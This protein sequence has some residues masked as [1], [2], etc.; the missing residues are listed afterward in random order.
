MEAIKAVISTPSVTPAKPEFAF[1]MTEEAAQKNFCILNKY[2]RD[3]GRA[4]A[5]QHKS[6]LGYGSEFRPTANLIHVFGLHP[7][8]K[9]MEALLQTGSDW[10]LDNLDMVSKSKDVEEA[11]QFGN[12]KG[13]E[14]NSE[15]LTSLVNKDVKHGYGLVLPLKKALRIPGLLMAPMNIQKQNTIDEF[16]RIMERDRLTHNQSYKWGS[17]TSVNSRVDKGPLLPCMFG[18]CLKRLINWTVAAR[19]KYPDTRILASKI[20]YKS[21]YRRC[22]LNA[23]T[24]IQTSTQLPDLNLLI[25]ALR[26]TFGGAPGP[27]EW[28]AISEPICDLAMAILQHPDWDPERLHAPNPELV[29]PAEIM[30][31]SIPFGVGRELIVDVPVDPRGTTDV[32]IDDTMGLTIDVAGSNNAMRLERAILLA[33]HVAAR[34]RHESEPIPR[35]EMAALAKLIA[36]AKLEERKTILG[37]N[38]DFRR[39]TISLPENK[40]EAWSRAIQDI[41]EEETVSAKELEKNIGRLVHLSLVLPFVHHFLSRLRELHRRANNRRKIKVTEIYKVDLELMLFFLKKAHQGVDMNLIA[42]R[43]PTHVFRSDSCPRGLGGYSH[44]G[45]AWRFYIPPELQFRASNNLLEHMAS[46]IT[47]WIDIL[48][49]RLQPGDCSLSLT[50]SSTSEGWSHKTNFKEDGEEPIQATTR[51]EVARDHARHFMDAKIKDYS[52]WFPGKE[53]DVADALSRDD[54][55]DNEELTNIL[56]SSVPQ[57]V[58]SH[59]EIV[60]LPNE[61]SSWLISVLEKLPVKAQLQ[62][63]H[64]RTKLGRGA[65][66]KNGVTPLD[67]STINCWTISQDTNASYSSELSPWLCIAEDFWDQLMTPWLKA[68]SE[69]PSH[70]WLRP[71]GIRADQIQPKTKMASLG[72]FYLAN[73]GPTKT[74][75]PTQSNKRPSPLAC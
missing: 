72:G 13:A 4:L 7:N 3:L 74:R 24:A 28:G 21:A 15:L 47:P 54:D 59:F 6:P 20:D 35:E 68:Q 42:Y 30:E 38:F 33:I 70:M 36:E 9:R 8:W 50:D 52:Q 55:R 60:P 17:G 11:I 63:R 18:A 2:G 37:W 22:H 49:G 26:L 58:P 67:S 44:E 48:A 71:S 19:R 10:A 41:I 75:T 73:L 69:V 64:T 14:D 12:H 62:E 66:G 23:R 25:I 40:F 27:F 39:L 31:D 53:N 45:W 51:L 46:V 43:K 16:G 1:E 29:P 65:D 61:I 32:Y 56:R 57:Q 5:A 34:P